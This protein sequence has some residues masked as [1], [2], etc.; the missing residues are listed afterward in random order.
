MTIISVPSSLNSFHSDFISNF[1]STLQIL[2]LFCSGD[3]VGEHDVIDAFDDVQLS[4][5]DEMDT[6]PF[7]VLMEVEEEKFVI[8]CALGLVVLLRSLC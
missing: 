7:K 3:V 5:G 8:A 2:S 4:L 1:A 6:K